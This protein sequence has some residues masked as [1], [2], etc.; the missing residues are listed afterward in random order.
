MPKEH[1]AK[2]FHYFMKICVDTIE[3]LSTHND[4]N[5][6]RERERDRERE[7]TYSERMKYMISNLKEMDVKLRLLFMGEELNQTFK[8]IFCITNIQSIDF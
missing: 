1:F 8:S 2:G 5:L 6:K 4:S 3:K 7:T